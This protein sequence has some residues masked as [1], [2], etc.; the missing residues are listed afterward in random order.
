M[1]PSTAVNRLFSRQ[2]FRFPAPLGLALHRHSFKRNFS[3]FSVGVFGGSSIISLYRDTTY[4]ATVVSPCS[5]SHSGARARL[6]SGITQNITFSSVSP[7]GTTMATDPSIRGMQVHH[8]LDFE[9]GHVLVTTTDG[10]FLALDKVEISLPCVKTILPRWEHRLPTM[11][12]L[13]CGMFSLPASM[14]GGGWGRAT[15]SPPSPLESSWS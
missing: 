4:L 12:K 7:E 14:I 8:L 10:V 15:V 6:D 9:C 2:L 11:I 13:I 3:T 1:V 5:M